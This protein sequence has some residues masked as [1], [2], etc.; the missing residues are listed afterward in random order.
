MSQT[1][2][3]LIEGTQILKAVEM[4]NQSEFLSM[5]AYRDEA[6]RLIKLE[7]DAIQQQKLR[8]FIDTLNVVI[9]E[10]VYDALDEFDNL[11]LA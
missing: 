6:I 1:T 10:Y 11:K 8:D 5:T 3:N 2:D 9:K 7:R 4:G